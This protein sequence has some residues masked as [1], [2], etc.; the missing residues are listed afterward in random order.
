MLEA[1]DIMTRNV[2]CIKK[3]IPVVDAI[4]VA[5]LRLPVTFQMISKRAMTEQLRVL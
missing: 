1:K 5:F 3:N 2:V 4:R